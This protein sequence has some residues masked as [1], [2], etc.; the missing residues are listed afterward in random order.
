ML[1]GGGG[2]LRTHQ[3]YFPTNSF[4]GGPSVGDSLEASTERGD[5]IF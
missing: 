3:I 4:Y 1:K 5:P 2:R